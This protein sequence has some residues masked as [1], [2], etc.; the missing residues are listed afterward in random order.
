MCFLLFSVGEAPP[1]Y[2][3]SDP[4]DLA[5]FLEF[6]DIRLVRGAFIHELAASQGSMPR[7]QEAERAS[8]Q[9]SQTALV[10]LLKS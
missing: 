9:G 8:C 3:T 2:D 6:A 1:A 7:R 4:S 10:A 5:Q